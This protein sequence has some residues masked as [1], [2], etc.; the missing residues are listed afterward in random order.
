MMLSL[1]QKSTGDLPWYLRN[2]GSNLG[3]EGDDCLFESSLIPPDAE[4]NLKMVGDHFHPCS[5]YVSS[6][7][8][9]PVPVTKR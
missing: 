3:Q 1:I 6:N 7:F 9:Q 8:S 4:K 5:S 2:P